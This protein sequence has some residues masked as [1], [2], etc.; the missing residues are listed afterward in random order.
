MSDREAPY[1]PYIPQGG[2]GGGAPQ[3]GNQRTAALQ[4]VGCTRTFLS[5]AYSDAAVAVEPDSLAACAFAIWTKQCETNHCEGSD[6]IPLAK[7]HSNASCRRSVAAR[8]PD[9]RRSLAYQ[10]KYKL[11]MILFTAN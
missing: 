9:C 10:V 3:G 7:K 6:M 2:Q 1:D 8:S 11:T 4:A 5:I